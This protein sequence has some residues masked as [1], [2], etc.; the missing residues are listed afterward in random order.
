[1]KAS[2]GNFAD[3]TYH[4][5][6]EIII[7]FSLLASKEINGLM[8]LNFVWRVRNDIMA[9]SG[10]EMGYVVCVCACV[11]ARN[12]NCVCVRCCWRVAT[13]L[14]VYPGKCKRLVVCGAALVDTAINSR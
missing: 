4:H 13:L 10:G 11:R 6:L 2:K 3:G 8:T 14:A 7:D 1:M 12:Q 9:I 5:T